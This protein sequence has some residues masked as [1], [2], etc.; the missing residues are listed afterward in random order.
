MVAISSFRHDEM[1]SALFS[2]VTQRG[3]SLLKFRDNL[4]APSSKRLP[5]TSL[6]NCHYNLSNMAEK[7]QVVPAQIL[8]SIQS[9][10]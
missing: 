8:S 9:Q 5:E 1:R 3:N 2:D 7:A 10:L 4:L 6:R